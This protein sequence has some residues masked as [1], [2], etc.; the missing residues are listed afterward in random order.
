MHYLKTL[1][2]LGNLSGKQG[3]RH[4]GQFHRKRKEA[5]PLLDINIFRINENEKLQ[6]N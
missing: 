3:E 1:L 5:P 6:M 2:Y 4:V